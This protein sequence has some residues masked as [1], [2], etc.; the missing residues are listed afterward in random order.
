MKY[1][2]AISAVPMMTRRIT[3]VTKYGKSISASPHINGTM[4]RCLLPQIKK[5]SPAQP[6]SMAQTM[7]AV[8]TAVPISALL[9]KA[10][11]LADKS[12]S[13]YLDVNCSKFVLAGMYG[14]GVQK[15]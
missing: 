7:T 13:D 14:V 15:A 4:A 11:G 1:G 9:S 5:P 6:N 12:N 3:L 8:L 2:M 10:Q